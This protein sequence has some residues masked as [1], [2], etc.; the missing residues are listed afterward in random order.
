MQSDLHKLYRFSDVTTK[1]L[2]GIIY[3]K[4]DF[5]NKLWHE[6]HHLDGRERSLD[7]SDEVDLVLSEE[8]FNFSGMLDRMTGSGVMDWLKLIC[9]L[10][11]I[12]YSG[13]ILIL[14]TVNYIWVKWLLYKSRRITKKFVAPRDPIANIIPELTTKLIQVDGA[15]RNIYLD[16]EK[17]VGYIDAIGHSPTEDFTP[18]S[19]IP[20]SRVEPV[21]ETSGAFLLQFLNEEGHLQGHGA[22]VIYHD[23]DCVVTANHVYESSKYV[24]RYNSDKVMELPNPDFVFNDVAVFRLDKNIMSAFGF[25]SKKCAPVRSGIKNIV[26]V[27]KGMLGKAYGAVESPTSDRLFPFDFKHK[28]STDH[29]VSGS[30][31]LDRKGQV[32]AIHR[33]SL[34]SE[35]SN[36]ATA[37]EPILRMAFKDV[38]IHETY[39]ERHD[40]LFEETNADEFERNLKNR[41]MRKADVRRYT[42]NNNNQ[43]DVIVFIGG[44]YVHSRGEK[45]WADYSSDEDLP[46]YDSFMPENASKKAF[47]SPLEREV[48]LS[49]KGSQVSQTTLR[50]NS[51]VAL[52]YQTIQ[53][54]LERSTLNPAVVSSRN[55]LKSQQRCSKASRN[56]EGLASQATQTLNASGPVSLTASVKTHAPDP[57]EK[58]LL[59]RR[60]K[61]RRG[62]QKLQMTSQILKD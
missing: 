16:G 21:L 22:R 1:S 2:I 36:I 56:L 8:G 45:M 37:L 14:R 49:M 19:A 35:S 15:F 48:K 51:T 6:H 44:Q 39:E 26:S 42:E 53:K 57:K 18:E 10:I 11:C 4:W 23:I 29:M 54:S 30:P 13:I 3:P 17:V 9:V 59:K 25:K 55:A 12:L 32:V 52:K 61:R 34:N 62:A 58:V 47:R 20:G 5:T 43:L 27:F 40:A 60:R 7:F 38:I 46:D 50:R 33:G 28:I 31:V 41:N 24:R